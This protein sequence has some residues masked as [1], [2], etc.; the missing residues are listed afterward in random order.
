M[1]KTTVGDQTKSSGKR[2]RR[3]GFAAV[4]ILAALGIYLISS[5]FLDIGKKESLAERKMLVVL[6]FDNLGLPS[7]EYFADGITEEI[8][9]R[10]AEISELGVIARTSAIQYKNTDKEIQQ[11]V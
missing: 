6:P 8:T 7:D 10:L 11:I 2:V 9:S 3:L 4:G 1:T 5:Q